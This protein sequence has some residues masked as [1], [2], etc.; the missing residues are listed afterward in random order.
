MTTFDFG[1]GHGPV[2]AHQHPNG[3]GWV[4]DSATVATTAYI[5]PNARVYGDAWVA[6]DA[7]VYGDAQV[8]GNARVYGNAWVAGNAWVSGGRHVL[9]IGPIGSEDK[10]ITAWR[11]DGGHGLSVG[12]W[13][14]HQIDELA[15]EVLRRAPGY[16]AEYAAAEALIRVRIA[17]WDSQREE[18]A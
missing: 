4:A 10:T 3:G 2:P 11:T 15:A 16:V 6:G 18:P 17:E 14:N 9:T 12:C 7:R 8:Y 5:G 13:E 1:D